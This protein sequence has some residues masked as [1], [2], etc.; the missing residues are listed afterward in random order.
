MF[1]NAELI[2]LVNGSSVIGLQ[3]RRKMAVTAMGTAMVMETAIRPFLF[4]LIKVRR[5]KNA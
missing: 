5:M 1:Q 3:L 4:M 2:L